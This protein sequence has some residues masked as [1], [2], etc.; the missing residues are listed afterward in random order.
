MCVNVKFT[1]KINFKCKHLERS[2]SGVE[3][4]GFQN[5]HDPLISP[6]V[7]VCVRH[8]LFIKKAC[9]KQAMKILLGTFV[10]N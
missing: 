3:T 10:I 7:E 6:E 1:F 8:F 2:E 5:P 4:D 9:L